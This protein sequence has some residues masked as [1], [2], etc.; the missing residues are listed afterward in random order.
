MSIYLS[1]NAFR[2]LIILGSTIDFTHP[3]FLFISKNLLVQLS[4]VVKS[5][6]SSLG[7][8]NREAQVM[9]INAVK[10]VASAL[11][12]L[13]QSTKS[14]SGKNIHDPAMHHLKES[15]KVSEKIITFSKE[16]NN[17]KFL[18]K[19][20]QFKFLKKKNV[21]ISIFVWILHF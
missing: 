1:E 18:K 10:D 3:Q 5:G 20:K 12:D 17:L 13:M 16:I 8:P 21:F 15:A 11:A 4:E 14:A 19:K 2:V 6:A 7:S 9:L